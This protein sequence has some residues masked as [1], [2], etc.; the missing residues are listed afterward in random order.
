MANRS[1][2]AAVVQILSEVCRAR[3]VI[4]ATHNANNP[5]LMLGGAALL[6]AC[7]AATSRSSVSACGGLADRRVVVAAYHAHRPMLGAAAL[8]RACD[9]AA[10][11]SSCWACGG[12][13]D[14]RVVAHARHLRAGGDAA[15]NARQQRE[16]AGPC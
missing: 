13:T 16:Q 5:I 8:L 12:L 1:L 15:G 7:E 6:R 3:L 10:R 9:A 2:D 11:R 4:I 14:R